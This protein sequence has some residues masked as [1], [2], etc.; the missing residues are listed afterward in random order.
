MEMHTGKQFHFCTL[1]RNTSELGHVNLLHLSP[2]T[3][4]QAESKG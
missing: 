1:T 3:V 2:G 4:Q